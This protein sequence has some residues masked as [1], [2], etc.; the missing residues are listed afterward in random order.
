MTFQLTWHIALT[1]VYA[2]TCYTV[3]T[4]LTNLIYRSVKKS[5]NG[6]FWCVFLC[7]RPHM[8]D[9]LRD[10]AHL[11][12]VCRMSVTYIGPKSRTEMPRKTNIGIEVAHVTRDS[13]TTFKVK[14]SKVNLQGAGILCRPPAQLVNI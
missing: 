8:A 6:L 7:P 14:R 3:K 12:S 11:T 13:G 9:A 4:V 1:T 10:D 5:G 2:L